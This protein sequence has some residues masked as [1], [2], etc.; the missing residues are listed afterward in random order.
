MNQSNSCV[1]LSPAQL[2]IFLDQAI[3]PHVP[4]YNIGGYVVLREAVD[5]EAFCRAFEHAVAG[6]DAFQ[7]RFRLES[8][9]PQQYLQQQV[10]VLALHD[11]TQAKVPAQAAREWLDGLFEYRFQLDSEAPH[12]SA[13]VKV[14]PHEYWY[15]AVAHHLVIDG[16]GFGLWVRRLV[17]GYLAQTGRGTPP[18]V[19]E[20]SF[21]QSIAARRQRHESRPAA[22]IP[23]AQAGGTA[24]PLLSPRTLVATPQ[25]SVRVVRDL[26]EQQVQ[27]WS[28]LAQAHG[29]QLH[30]FL[31]S[32]VFSYFS[33]LKQQDCLVIGLPTHNR[34]GQE[35][36]IVGSY[37]NVVPCTMSLAQQGGIG[38]LMAM[39]KQAMTHCV[40]SQEVSMAERVRGAR[41]VGGR[42]AR[43]FDLQ[44]NYL[45]LDYQTDE[46][47]L[48]TETH[49]LANRWAQI[50]FS[51]NVCDFGSHQAMQLQVDVNEAYFTPMEAALLLDRLMYIAEQFERDPSLVLDKVALVPPAEALLVQD[52]GQ[53]KA[54][55]LGGIDMATRFDAMCERY[56]EAVALKSHAGELQYAAL[57]QQ[58]R[59]LAGW[60]RENTA[61]DTAPLAI[62]LQPAPAAIV[63]LLAIAM[64]R[65]PCVPLDPACPPQRLMH[66]LAD[67]QPALLLTDTAG[68]AKATMLGV[69]CVN[70]DAPD[71]IAA[72]AL[73]DGTA[74]LPPLGQEIATLPASIL[75]TSG[76]TG[77]PKGVIIPQSAI[78]RLVDGPD[79]LPLGPATVTLQAANIA[80]DVAAFEIWTALLN[81][82][83][84]VLRNSSMPDLD[85]LTRQIEAN[86]VNTLWLTAGLF[87][88]WVGKLKAVPPSL[89]FVLAGGDVVP[90]AAVC[91]LQAMKPDIVFINGYGPTENGIFSACAVVVAH[92]DPCQPI[93]I[94]KPVNGSTCYVVDAHGRL[95]PLGEPG[96]LWVGGAGVALGYLNQDE[97]TRARFIADPAPGMPGRLYKTGDQVRWR[98]DGQLD[99][100]GRL[101][102]QVKIRGF[103][104]EIDEIENCLRQHPDVLEVAVVVVGSMAADK[105]LCAHVRPRGDVEAGSLPAALAS[106]LRYSLPDYMVPAHIALIDQL[107]LNPNGKIDRERLRSMGLPL[108]QHDTAVHGAAN[109]TEQ[110][111]WQC[112]TKALPG[113]TP[114]LDDNFFEQGGHSLAA[115]RI[116]ADLN[117]CYGIRLTLVDVLKLPTIRLQAE[118]VDACRALLTDSTPPIPRSAPLDEVPMSFVQ[119]QMWLSHLLN[120][121]SHEYNVPGAYRLSGPLNRVALT[122]ALRRIIARHQP[123]SCSVV[124]R[125][126]TAVLCP[127]DAQDFDLD[128]QDLAAMSTSERASVVAAALQEERLRSFDLE[129]DLPIRARVL[130]LGQDEHVLL[131][132]LHHMAVDG[133]SLSKLLAELTALYRECKGGEPAELA[134]LQLS[135]QDYA[136][137]QL[138]QEGS[139]AF[140]QAAQ[141]WRDQLAGVPVQHELPLDRARPEKANHQGRVLRGQLDPSSMAAVQQLAASQ[142]ISL[143]CLLQ[144]AFAVIVGEYSQQRD[145]LVGTPVSGRFHTELYPNIGCFINTQLVRTCYQPQDSLL[146]VASRN[147]AQWTEHLGHHQVPF[148]H[149]LDALAPA[150]SRSFNPLFQ[151]WF[152]LH[153]QV[154]GELA[155]DG[156]AVQMLR[157][158]E[159]N[160]KFDLMVSAAPG[161]QGLEIEWL[162]AESLFS[163]ASMQ[164][165]LDGYLQLLRRLPELLQQAVCEIP[166]QLG[167]AAAWPTV[168]MAHPY[169][170][171]T[172]I[173]DRVFHHASLTPTAAAV[174]DG[175]LQLTYAQL[176]DKVCRLG[177]LLAECG[178][179]QGSRVAVCADRTVGGLVAMLAAQALGAAYVPVDAKLPAARLDFVLADADA[180][181]LL[182]YAE[183]LSPMAVGA[184]DVVLLDGIADPD[185]LSD[186][187]GTVL[188][189]GGISPDT[190]AYLI[191]TSGSSGMPK[192]VRVSRAN[193][194]H[195]VAAMTERYG[196][197]VCSHYAVNSAF[198]TDLG[199]TTLYLG[200]WHG[201]CLH[202]MNSA[203]MLDGAAVSRY[204]QQ[205]GIDVMKITPGHFAALCDDTL[206]PAPVPQRFLILGGEVLRRELLQAIGATCQA[207]GCR[208]INHY[209]PT[210]ATIGCLTHEI[211]LQSLPDVAPL[212][213]P[214]P[215]EALRIQVDGRD[216]PHGCWGELVIG[217]PAVSLG[218]NKRADLTDKAF[219]QL[220]SAGGQWIPHYRTGDRVRLDALGR[221]EFGGR[222]DD[223][224]KL[225]GFR[226]E[227]A[228]ID[229][230]LLRLPGIS[231]AVTLL[232]RDAAG[233]DALAS[234]VVDSG[235][236]DLA[237]TQAA[238]RRSLPDYMLP[239][240]IVALDDMPLLGNGKPDRQA[241][242]RRLGEQS[243]PVVQG[244]AT[245]TEQTLHRIMSGLLQRQQL[246]VEQRFFDAGGNSLLVTR[247]ANELQ[248]AMGVHIPVR[249]L[250]E[251]HSVRSLAT[252]VD[253]LL[254]TTRPQEAGED[255]IE[256]EI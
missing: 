220:E 44:F 33:V 102:Q 89:R 13:L 80:F 51:F 126:Q 123:L 209:G 145:V 109:E 46:T 11:F 162:Y 255:L 48:Q 77:L 54:F 237:T 192:G 250:M 177:C 24:M 23:A 146:A 252:L 170:T 219:I 39:T 1:D 202:L 176:A 26:S 221:I 131:V 232:H 15:C 189:E 196:F 111:V 241:L 92:G 86:G 41:A 152:V 75:Y 6:H 130:A 27:A 158:D 97:L 175:D 32:L 142:Q 35:K 115:M 40:R 110:R 42:H 137:H 63:A 157:A 238:L 28:A 113:T 174:R 190:E 231:H 71:F 78:M 171:S 235:R 34:R 154:A 147:A 90:P 5:E 204:V 141:Y 96:E 17:A 55:P 119:R 184:V 61:D 164:R 191:Y 182:G 91:K 163:E 2:D 201:A 114:S 106:H 104:I 200:L 138:A 179:V 108:A 9:V 99:Y 217:G 84:L 29:F 243:V 93:P 197:E 21:L 211:D 67:A 228:E 112:W 155:L 49:Y 193:L 167:L 180:T 14:G 194:A 81:G 37:V 8:G 172:C 161:A 144:A 7:I 101:D 57:Q 45:K 68:Q 125:G 188:P 127:R 242:L 229:T 207:R 198:H 43:M 98:P 214:L 205:Q 206:Y 168:A 244:P 136:L 31:L 56:P 240:V 187:Q 234:F 87:D 213:L 36:T 128:W 12:R 173:A 105:C 22:A 53:G 3:N 222:F 140:E 139:P 59:R 134:P 223:Q 178:V 124:R 208:V 186:Y 195:Y 76:S 253:A 70:L 116:L 216:V 183:T 62:H 153:A 20:T 247:L 150:Q 246:S 121:G 227:L 181:V 72:L 120:G 82:G 256:I 248:L 85:E 245:P 38:A 83:T 100:L 254:L 64:L 79:F 165:M 129:R 52:W 143:F 95:L 148:S 103:R 135:Y 107:P 60:L 50:P 65:R 224:I 210:E 160:T 122:E 249:L 19:P 16:W 132:T 215:G 18:A 185:W 66:I 212:G 4:L 58:A 251:N 117:E 230:S 203:L 239:R 151:L 133:W 73:T 88:T 149:V 218:Y 118:R 25:P 30:H 169:E 69:P 226:V 10:H 236:F 156:L 94:G 47:Y 199:N 233:Q 74:L 166:A 159:A 225:R